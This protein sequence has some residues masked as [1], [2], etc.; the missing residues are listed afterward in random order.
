MTQGVHLQ[1]TESILPHQN[2][3][4]GKVHLPPESCY[5]RG[6]INLSNNRILLNFPL[7]ILLLFLIRVYTLVSEK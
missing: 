1:S 3:Y 6:R 5:R 4:Q 2:I 7:G